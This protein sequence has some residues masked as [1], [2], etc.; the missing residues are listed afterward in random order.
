MSIKKNLLIENSKYILLSV[1]IGEK[2]VM[3]E[4]NHN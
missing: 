4:R 2:T 3:I 1:Q